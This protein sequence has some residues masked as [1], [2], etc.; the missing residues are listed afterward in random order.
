MTPKTTPPTTALLQYLVIS[1][2]PCFLAQF[3]GEFY[4]L[5]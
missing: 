3:A 1:D 2:G 4:W 5:I